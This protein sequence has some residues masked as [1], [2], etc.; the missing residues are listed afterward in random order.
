MKTQNAVATRAEFAAV[1]LAAALVMGS[2][3]TYAQQSVEPTTV[4]TTTAGA[5]PILNQPYVDK[6]EWREKPV[7][8]RYVHGGF[9]GTEARFAFYF[10]AREY[11]KGRFFQHITPA[12]AGETLDAQNAVVGNGELEQLKCV[13]DRA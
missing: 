8:H 3:K 12:P 6:D 11:Y 7:H 2:D 10:P 1:L 5:D 4:V 13:I 9:K